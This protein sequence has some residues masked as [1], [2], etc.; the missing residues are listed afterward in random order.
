[1]AEPRRLLIP[2]LVRTVVV[3]VGGRVVWRGAGGERVARKEEQ[4]QKKNKGVMTDPGLSSQ[5]SCASPG[6][7]ACKSQ[8]PKTRQRGVGTLLRGEACVCGLWGWHMGV[9][10][11]E[12]MT[13]L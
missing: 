3:P 9:E 13:L 1:M 12:G 10:E 6:R 7:G 11:C 8:H 5:G 2:V 4:T